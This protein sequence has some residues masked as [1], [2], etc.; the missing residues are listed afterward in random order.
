MDDLKM[1]INK[2]QL[3]IAG[4]I[5]VLFISGFCYSEDSSLKEMVDSQGN[6]YSV[7]EKGDIYT[8]GIP[9][10]GR[11]P[12]SV[13]NLAYYFNESLMLEV[14]GYLDEAYKMMNE[15]LFLP[16]TNE[17]VKL[18]QHG[19]RIRIKRIYIDGGEVLREKI[20][21]FFDIKEQGDGTLDIKPRVM[22][23]E[24]INE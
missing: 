7:D 5:I 8:E 9:M 20:Q 14:N 16:E 12:A 17:S 23:K 10:P 13:E 3:I 6:K 15:I 24:N 18:A 19:M 22:A 1:Q 2:K 4:A 11:Q 21:A